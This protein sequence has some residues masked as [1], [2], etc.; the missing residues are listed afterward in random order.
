MK[1]IKLLLIGNSFLQQIIN[2][3]ELISEDQ[4]NSGRIYVNLLF[5]I[6]HKGPLLVGETSVLN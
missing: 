6:F 1:V 4:N 3:S 2:K 5:L